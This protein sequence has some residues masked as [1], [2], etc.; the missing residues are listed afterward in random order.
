MLSVYYPETYFPLTAAAVALVN[1]QNGM[2]ASAK[3]VK[4]HIPI[5]LCVCNNMPNGYIIKGN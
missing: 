2:S 3:I 1:D 4:G 5:A